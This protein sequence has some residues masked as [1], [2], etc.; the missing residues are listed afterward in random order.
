[1][2]AITRIHIALLKV[3]NV[4]IIK[5]LVINVILFG[6]D[7]SA[8]GQKYSDG[9]P[10]AHL[11]MNAQDHGIVLRYGDGPDQCDILGARDVWVFEANGTYYMHYDA[12]GPKGW[13][14]SLAISKD[15]VH[16][17]KRGPILDFGKAGEDDAAS[18]SYGVTFYDGHDWH[19]YY[20]GTPNASNPPDLV[21]SFPYLT[22]KA[23]GNSPEGP[24]IKQKSVVP[25]RTKPGTYYSITASPGHVI[26]NGDE[27]L[28]FFSST[29]RSHESQYVQRTL[30]IA[31]TKDLD[32][33]WTID[34]KPMVPIEEQIENSS[35]YY[36]KSIKTWFLFTNH[37]GVEEGRE[38]TDA[39]WVYWSKDLNK[40]DPKNKAIVLDGKNCSWSEKCIGLPSVVEV[41]NRLALFYDAPGGTGTSHMKRNVGLAWLDLPLTIPVPNQASIIIHTNAETKEYNPMI[42]G[43]FMEHFGRQIYGGIFEPGS[44]LAD[45]QGFRLDVIE[46]LKELKVPVIRWPGGCFVDAYH[47]QKGVGQEREAYGDFRW[48]VIEPNTFGTDEFVEL[49]SRLGA[50]PY[51]CHNGLADVQEMA[52]WV[53]YCNAT[54]GKFADM[55]K[56]NGHPEP[57]DVK[58]WSVGNERYDTAY[59][60]R[61]REAAKIMKEIAP[62]VQTTCSGSQGGMKKTG[63]KVSPFLLETAGQYLD[64]ISV[65]NYWLARGNELPEYDY[66]TAVA[67]SEYPEAYIKLVIESLEESG[68]RDQ[69]KI[70]FDEWNLRAWQH[71]G[72]PRNKVDD[73]EDPEILKLIE[74]RIEGNDLNSQYTMADALFA[75]SF[76]N[77]CLRHSEDVTMANI[78]PLVNTRGPLYVHPEGLVRRTHFHAMAM[79]AKLLEEQVATI[80][81][82]AE[83]LIHGDDTVAVMDA[84]ATVDTSG[85]NWAISM[86]N[87]HPS[88]HVDCTVFIGDKP[89]N[90]TYKAT[91]LTGDSPDAYNDIEHPDSVIPKEMQLHFKKGVTSLPP[92]SLIIIH[93]LDFN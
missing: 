92:H 66:L 57:F 15:L 55:R 60:H 52:A 87:R 81:F 78:A 19:M 69:L 91:V 51:I 1:M 27:Y 86:V 53:E 11:R 59:I 36:E 48:G 18:A 61:V 85:R 37:I 34:P 83:Q 39:I 46:A 12:A 13:L 58:F 50:E 89:L 65:H 63:F 73:Y 35:L 3:C 74:K 21:P 68:M 7:H 90:G 44:P 45:E 77:A 9:R 23:K 32:G 26:K 80:E 22:M 2:R 31:R 79:Y 38:F 5:V 24:W 41:D 17:E 14:S 76:F 47:W 43:G 67:K 42:F 71:P 30:G 49:C 8:V 75:A 6:F 56:D 82:E 25:F 88:E 70:A 54:E 72:F 62:G 93:L 64:Y 28:Q 40:W 4:L 84:I 20:L 10:K 33:S 16:W 29:T